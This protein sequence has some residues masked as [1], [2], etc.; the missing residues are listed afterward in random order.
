MTA[1]LAMTATLAMTAALLV[2]GIDLVRWN[3]SWSTFR[4]IPVLSLISPISAQLRLT[5]FRASAWARAASP[6]CLAIQVLLQVF[7]TASAAV[8]ANA[9]VIA[10]PA[11]LASAAVI[12]R[13]AVRKYRHFGL[14]QKLGFFTPKL[15]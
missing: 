13:A 12:A 8:I 15:T 10:S 3:K 4:V 2:A 1:G 14:C 5:A 7:S 6:A 9:A 11:V